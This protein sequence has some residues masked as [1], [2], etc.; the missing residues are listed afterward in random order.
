LNPD[1]AV[2]DE[3]A[4]LAG[5]TY[6]F[7]GPQLSNDLRT[8]PLGQVTMRYEGIAGRRSQAWA[9]PSDIDAGHAQ[10]RGS[11]T[12]TSSPTGCSSTFGVSA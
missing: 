6:A 9:F 7:S 12:R 2:L 5:S 3:K 11:W 1:D 8:Q 10:M 4:T